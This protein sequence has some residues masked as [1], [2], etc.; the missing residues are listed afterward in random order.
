VLALR[1]A[2][3]NADRAVEYLFSGVNLSALASGGAGAGGAED[4][5]DDYG[6][7]DG[8]SDPFPGGAGGNPFAALA[9]NPNFNLIR[10]R[11]LQDPNFY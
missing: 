2:F 10:Q 4:M 6:D 7:E 11:M 8:S 9:Q 1:A 5:G 3:G